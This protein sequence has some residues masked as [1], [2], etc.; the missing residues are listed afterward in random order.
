MNI[1]ELS[2]ETIKKLHRIALM[3]CIALTIGVITWLIVESILDYYGNRWSDVLHLV[4]L[5]TVFTSISWRWRYLGGLLI[6]AL[7]GILLWDRLGWL[8][9]YIIADNPRWDYPI[10]GGGASWTVITTLWVLFLA[11]GILFIV[12][13]QRQ[14]SA[15]YT[16]ADTRPS[17]RIAALSPRA[18]TRIKW[19]GRV[20]LVI[21]ALFMLAGILINIIYWIERPDFNLADT[22]YRIFPNGLT[23]IIIGF[24]VFK[25]PL[26]AGLLMI[27]HTINGFYGTLYGNVSTLTYIY[28]QHDEYE[29]VL[30]W[31]TLASLG[32]MLIPLS[33]GVLSTIYAWWRRE[34]G[35]LPT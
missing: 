28:T 3:G 15:I 18:I 21:L 2:P 33:G 11:F 7:S 35:P 14:R 34:V 13:G 23:V 16:E 6:V 19:I 25:W 26:F 24:S 31:A 1:Q 22:L 27:V 32:F 30:I 20:I 12:V 4:A 17:G 10:N 9:Y 8:L 5:F 29:P